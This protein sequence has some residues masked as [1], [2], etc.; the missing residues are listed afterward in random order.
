M[1]NNIQ[2]RVLASIRNA[3]INSFL[4][5]LL[6]VLPNTRNRRHPLCK[7]ALRRLTTVTGHGEFVYILILPCEL[8]GTPYTQGNSITLSV[9]G[10]SKENPKNYRM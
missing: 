10:N 3:L 8:L 4:A 5:N 7:L 2:I 9:C 6:F 1:I